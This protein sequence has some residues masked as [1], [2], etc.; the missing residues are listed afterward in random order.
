MMDG[1]EILIVDENGQRLGPGEVGEVVLR[2]HYLSPGYWRRPDMTQ[3]AFKADPDGSGARLYNT[4]DLG[5]LAPDGCLTCWGRKDLQVKVR[6]HRVELSEV[7][8]ALLRLPGVREAAAVAAD[9]AYGGRRIVA[10]V[11]PR[12]SPAPTVSRIRAALAAVLPEYMIPSSFVF[13]GSM[14]MAGNGK[15]DRLGLPDPPAVPPVLDN[16]CTPPRNALED[17]LTALW[18]DILERETDRGARTTFLSWARHPLLAA[19][20]SPRSRR[21]SGKA[22]RFPSCCRRPPIEELAAAIK[23]EALTSREPS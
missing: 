1:V 14:P 11:V 5:S 4:G 21:I 18:E 13:L 7:E 6:G 12:E 16:D 9:D 19:R 23:Q 22:C 8:A 3:A 17:W 2:G 15:V 10:Y 20:S